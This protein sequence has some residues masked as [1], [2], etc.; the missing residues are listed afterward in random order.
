METPAYVLNEKLLRNNLQLIRDTAQEAG[1]EIILA[2]K[3]FAWWR[4]FPI[5]REYIHHTTASSLNEAQLSA[6]KFG[7]YTYTYSPSYEE[8]TFQQIMQL[9]E[10]VTFTSLSHLNR[11]SPLISRYN[12]HH[13][14]CG[15]R[16]NPEQSDIKTA[17][18]NPCA[19]GSR[20]GITA[21]DMPKELPREIEGFHFHCLC[22][23]N[24]DSLKKVLDKVEKNFAQWLPQLKWINMGGGHLMTRKGYNIHLLIETLQKF[25]QR[26][27]NLHI[28]LEP[29]SAFLWQTGCLEAYVTDIVENH[30]IRTAIIN[31]SFTCHMPDCLEMPYHPNIK[32]AKLIDETSE[33]QP[34]CYRI[35]GNSCLSGDW[36]GTWQFDHPLEIG[37]KIIFEDMIHYTTVK[38]TMFNGIDHPALVLLRLDG[39]REILRTFKYADY[40]DRM[41]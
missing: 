34:N 21:E 22:E 39:S 4:T 36:M 33:M 41:D 35:G 8:L 5:F 28:I 40:R 7:G 27:P 24:S 1:V 6:E 18:Y 13:I 12:N 15:L 14:S 20:F 26:H 32:G 10:H 17:L 25:K 2:L 29:G 37:E 38:T 11:F 23:N 16:I 19:P 9:S 3:A 30:H 31:A